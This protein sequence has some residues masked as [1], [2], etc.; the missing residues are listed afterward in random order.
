M[1]PSM[2]VVTVA[3]LR[4]VVEGT[5]YEDAPIATQVP[6]NLEQVFLRVTDI[7]GSQI[8]VP[9]RLYDTTVQ[10]DAYGG[11]GRE[12]ESQADELSRIVRE[13]M[14]AMRSEDCVI[15]RVTTSSL[16][17][18]PDEGFEPARPRFIVQATIRWHPV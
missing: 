4:D 16:G 8:T 12:G 15:T 14:P 13:A 7:G 1:L 2:E 9:A 11:P 17:R 18:L 10:I 3:Y 6:R 5:D